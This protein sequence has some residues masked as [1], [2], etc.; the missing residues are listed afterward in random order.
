MCPADPHQLV[1]SRRSPR[2]NPVHLDPQV[3]PVTVALQAIRAHPD[4]PVR[5]AKTVKTVS[6]AQAVPQALLAL[7]ASMAPQAI[8]VK[9]G[10]SSQS[11][12]EMP[13]KLE[14][15]A[16][17]ATK[18][19]SNEQFRSQPASLKCKFSTQEPLDPQ[20]LT[21]PLANPVRKAQSDPPDP[22]EKTANPAR[23][24]QL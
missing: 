14:T 15:M 19:I 11:C 9:T 20:D 18:V 17:P 8:R 7:P 10:R 6:P 23:R 1:L 13:V 24:E 4:P 12:Q 16:P 5:P 21:A 3:P 22:Q 2:A